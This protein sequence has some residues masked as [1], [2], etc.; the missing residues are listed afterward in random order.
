MIKMKQYTQQE[1]KQAERLVEFTEE[2][3]ERYNKKMLFIGRFPPPMHGA[4]K[5]NSEY[6][7]VLDRQ[8]RL[9]RL[10]LNVFKKFEDIGKKG[11]IKGIKTFFI[12]I[13][14]LLILI[15]WRPNKVYFEIATVGVAFYRDSICVLLCKLFRRKILF[16]VHSSQVGDGKYYKFIFKNTRIILLSKLLENEWSHIY[17]D[18]DIEYLPNGIPDELNKTLY[19]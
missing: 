1:I 2:Y 19:D 11:V 17:D 7:K 16:H 12:Y 8:Y 9:I 14:L 15:F 6:Y 13:K 5:M 18:K 4:A 3:M 10:K